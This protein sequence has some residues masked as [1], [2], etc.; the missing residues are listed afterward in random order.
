[1]SQSCII[2]FSIRL[3]SKESDSLTR[4]LCVCMHACVFGSEWMLC[5]L[6]KVSV[7]G[8][9]PPQQEGETA[10]GERRERGSSGKNTK[11]NKK[12]LDQCTELQVSC[13]TAGGKGDGIAIPHRGRSH[14]G[15]SAR[16]TAYSVLLWRSS[17]PLSPASRR[18]RSVSAKYLVCSTLSLASS[19]TP[20]E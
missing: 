19:G 8:E 4:L 3:V 12:C 15:A 14:Y 11:K 5:H 18:L 7:R 13:T 10:N 6:K 1:M 17:P 9:P 20:V 2:R 16:A